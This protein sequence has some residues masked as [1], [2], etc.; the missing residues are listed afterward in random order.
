MKPKFT[1]RAAS[2]VAR[3]AL[4]PGDPVTF[5]RH[6]NG[7]QALHFTTVHGT[8]VRVMPSGRIA[9]RNGDGP[10][11]LVEPELVRPAG[12]P[13]AIGEMLDAFSALFNPEPASQP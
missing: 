9:V 13:S 11:E 3:A 8:V 6:V 1:T 5:M 10:A 7:P 12:Q 4:S 2:A